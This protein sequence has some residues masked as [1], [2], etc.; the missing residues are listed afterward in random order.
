MGVPDDI[1]SAETRR[2]DEAPHSPGAIHL[3]YLAFLDFG[4]SS[5]FSSSLLDDMMGKTK[6]KWNKEALT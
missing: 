3:D 1:R 6:T 5:A 2:D 4:G